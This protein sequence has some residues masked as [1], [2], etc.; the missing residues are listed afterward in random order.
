MFPLD[1]LLATKP[2][3]EVYEA[4]SDIFALRLLGCGSTDSETSS[5]RLGCHPGDV[6]YYRGP[7]LQGLDDPIGGKG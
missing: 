2:E 4:L 3:E 5:N 7:R 1:L 6:H